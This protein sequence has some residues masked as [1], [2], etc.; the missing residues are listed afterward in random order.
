[1]LERKDCAYKNLQLSFFVVSK[2]P[3]AEQ[4]AVHVLQE[5]MA[6]AVA[7]AVGTGILT[8]SPEPAGRIAAA[9]LAGKQAFVGYLAARGFERLASQYDLRVDHRTHW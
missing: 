3:D 2:G 1:M 6:S 7:A 8:P 9:L 5:A 4:A